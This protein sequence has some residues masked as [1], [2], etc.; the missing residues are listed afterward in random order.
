MSLSMMLMLVLKARF[1]LHTATATSDVNQT[2]MF[3]TGVIIGKIEF[4][5]TLAS[6]S[7]HSPSQSTFALVSCPAVLFTWLAGKCGVLNV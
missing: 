6:I 2:W 1:I 7:P 3:I 4:K 5:Q